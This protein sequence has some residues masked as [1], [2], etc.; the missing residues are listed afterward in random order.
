MERQEKIEGNERGRSRAGH[1]VVH[2]RSWW[3]RAELMLL[4]L[5]AALLILFG[6]SR[7]E[8]VLG[9][10]AAMIQ[11]ALLKATAAGTA[12][13]DFS[14]AAS[15][16]QAL[17]PT[18]SSEARPETLGVSEKA[19]Q[20][21][22]QARSRP[23]IGSP[24]GI[25]RIPRVHLEVPVLDG[26]EELTLNHAVGRIR[27][28]ARLGERGN[29]GIAGHRDSFFRGLKD[30]RVGDSLELETLNGSE[31]YTVDEIQIVSPDDVSV[32]QPRAVSSLTL[33]T[34]YP[35]YYVGSAPQR[36]VVTASL[37]REINSGP[38]DSLLARK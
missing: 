24:L 1:G 27:G 35:F 23:E 11:F 19:G 38:G 21:T 26:T 15:V 10:R 32:L 16:G 28:T 29:I 31:T 9:S 36:Y 37:T 18:H 6:A 25:L 14:A 20:E 8:G 34:C 30:V 5:G 13:E 22:H 17:Q 7:L 4:T 12:S 3:R 2:K 33:V